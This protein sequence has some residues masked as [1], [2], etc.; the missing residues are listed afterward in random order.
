MP[1]LFLLLIVLPFVELWLLLTMGSYTSV[2]FTLAFVIL[3]G[4]LGAVLLRYQGLFAWRNVQ[5]DLREGRMPTDSLLDGVMIIVAA[6]LLITPGVLTDF[7]GITLL[8]PPCRRFYRW[9]LSRWFK[10]RF[11][12]HTTVSSTN[13]AAGRSQVI[14][15]YVIEQ[16]P[17]DEPP[18]P[19]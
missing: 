2:E 11:K 14:D 3:T 7:F 19:Q 1:W 4:I 12:L 17:R 9:L 16:A 15:S 18:R 5:R 10:A 13:A 8:I 6:A